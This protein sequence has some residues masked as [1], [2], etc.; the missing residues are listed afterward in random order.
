[1]VD[2]RVRAPQVV[3]SLVGL[4]VLIGVGVGVGVALTR[5]KSSSSSS[6]S[7]SSSS[8]SGSTGAV[9]VTNPNDPSSFVKDSRLKHSFWG[10]AY[11]PEGSQL[12]SCGNS[13][14]KPPLL[15]TRLA[16]S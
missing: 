13:L 2:R 5:N 1:M 7:S 6:T 9:N 10:L 4:L 8:T 14:G 15:F 12:P 11:T 16:V 3:G